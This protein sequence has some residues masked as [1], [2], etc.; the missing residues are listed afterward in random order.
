M[1]DVLV[2]ITNGDGLGSLGGQLFRDALGWPQNAGHKAIK[3]RSSMT[4]ILSICLSATLKGLNY[5]ARPCQGQSSA[6]SVSSGLLEGSMDAPFP[7]ISS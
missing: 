1:C 4:R 5:T 3:A 2:R 6:P 7:I